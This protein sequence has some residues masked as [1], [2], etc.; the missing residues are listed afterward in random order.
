MERVRRK[1]HDGRFADLAAVVDH[2]NQFM[3]LSLWESEKHDLIEYRLA[4]IE[5]LLAEAKRTMAQMPPTDRVQARE[6]SEHLD[7]MLKELRWPDDITRR[8]A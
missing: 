4:R 2:Y 1:P 7:E 5:L 8:G 6:V 3:K